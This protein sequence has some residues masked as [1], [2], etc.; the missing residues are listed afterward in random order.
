MATSILTKKDSATHVTVVR[1]KISGTPERPRLAV[2]KSNPLYMVQL[3]MIRQG[4]IAQAHGHSFPGPL[5]KQA[6][7]VGKAIAPR[8]RRRASLRYSLMRGGY[9]YGGK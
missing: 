4:D 8:Q 9:N 7:E 3:S 1:A 2:Y 6:L 5:S